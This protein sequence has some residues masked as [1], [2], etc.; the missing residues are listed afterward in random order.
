MFLDEL[1]RA[2]TRIPLDLVVAP[3]AVFTAHKVRNKV[4]R[5]YLHSVGSDA[6]AG[7]A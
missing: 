4:Q 1:L 6:Y 5:M 2:I 3:R 7:H